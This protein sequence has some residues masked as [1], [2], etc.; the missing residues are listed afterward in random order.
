MK[1]I[2]L[3]SILLYLFVF[4]LG[5]VTR[6]TSIYTCVD[7][8]PIQA[9][10]TVLTCPGF[11]SC[12]AQVITCPAGLDCSV[13]CTGELGC[14]GAKI[15]CADGQNCA[16]DC[17]SGPQSCTDVAIYCPGSGGNCLV[18]SSDTQTKRLY[19]YSTPTSGDI[20]IDAVDPKDFDVSNFGVGIMLVR[21]SGAGG[22]EIR[23]LTHSF[24]AVIPG[25]KIFV[26]QQYPSS[27]VLNVYCGN[28]QVCDL[29]TG[30]DYT[31]GV[32]LYCQYSPICKFISPVNVPIWSGIACQYDLLSARCVQATN[33]NCRP[34]YNDCTYDCAV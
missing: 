10:A 20:Q 32:T 3:F 5:F 6:T 27:M 23:G 26:E 12:A 24:N 14:V 2:N 31:P 15:Y 22:I 13:S 19:V 11:M 21:V 28:S 25:R 8:I 16:V 33:T 34:I 1:K 9:Y 29:V 18:K 4:Q 30:Q 7:L 17:S